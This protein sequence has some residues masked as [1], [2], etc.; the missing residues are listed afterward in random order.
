ML[1]RFITDC[2]LPESNF[3]FRIFHSFPQRDILRNRVNQQVFMAIAPRMLA[4]IAAV[5]CA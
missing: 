2:P 3:F 4:C 1:R 5:A